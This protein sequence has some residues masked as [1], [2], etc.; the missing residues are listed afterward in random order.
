MKN[1]TNNIVE[2]NSY[3]VTEMLN[4]LKEEP[5]NALLF[6]HQLK[7][8]GFKHDVQTY[9]AMVRTFCYWG[10]DMKLDSLFLEVII[11]GEKRIWG[12]RFLICL[13]N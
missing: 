5:E 6:F 4:S 8:S 10:M 3:W 2:V 13:R 12:L 7:E 9:M 11:C 1:S